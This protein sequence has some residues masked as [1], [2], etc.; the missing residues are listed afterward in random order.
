MNDQQLF[1]CLLLDF[2]IGVVLG[3][4][5]VGVL[6]FLNIQHLLDVVQSSGSPITT[7][8]I[9]VGGCCAYFGLGATITGFHFAVMS[10]DGE[11]SS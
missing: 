1:R 11:R 3:G 8:V 4:L 7:G 10:N 9:L 2:A 6:L 5:F